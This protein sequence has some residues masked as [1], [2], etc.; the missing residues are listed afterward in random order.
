[1]SCCARCCHLIDM[2]HTYLHYFVQ[3]GVHKGSISILLCNGNHWVTSVKGQ[4]CCSFAV[5]LGQHPKYSWRKWNIFNLRSKLMED[6][7]QVAVLDPEEVGGAM[8]HHRWQ[9]GIFFSLHYYG[10]E[11]VDHIYVN[12]A[13]VV[14]TYEHLGKE[15]KVRNSLELS[16]MS[17]FTL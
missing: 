17:T 8:N 7:V 1:M 11:V 5:S 16:K 3:E 2:K 12:V 10:H 14:A 13:H 9:V 6:T 4:A 15:N